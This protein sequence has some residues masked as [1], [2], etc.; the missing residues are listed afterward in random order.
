MKKLLIAGALAAVGTASTLV[1]SPVK[2]A[3][4]STAAGNNCA[5]FNGSSASTVTYNG[6]ND[7]TFQA[8]AKITDISF[9]V[10]GLTSPDPIALTGL[11]Y[12][13]D[14]FATAGT[15]FNGGSYDAPSPS[16]GP[17]LLGGFV[18]APDGV[19]GSNFAIKF[20]ISPGSF[21]PTNNPMKF[22]RL[23]VGSYNTA[24]TLFQSQTR[25]SY[26]V[27]DPTTSA[28]PGPLPRFG[29]A[30]AFSFSRKARQRIKQAG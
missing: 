20:T 15:S 1:S 6:F 13:F 11:E 25:S 8:N 3:C 10:V 21:A 12:S 7:A 27:S 18:N 9:D 23:N 16:S 22:I 29:A 26:P 24:E 28:A 14:N 30:A 4:I 5:T 17:D 19:I 2:A